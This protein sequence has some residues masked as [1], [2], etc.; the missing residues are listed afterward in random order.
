MSPSPSAPLPASPGASSVLSQQVFQDRHIQHAVRQQLFQPGVFCLKCLQP[1]SIG[2][3][4]ASELRLPFVEGG[5]TD[6]VTPADLRG[7]H[8]TLLFRQDR[9]DL[10]FAE[11]ALPHC[12][13]PCD[14]LSI[15]MRDQSGLRSNSLAILLPVSSSTSPLMSSVTNARPGE[16]NEPGKASIMM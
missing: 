3:V 10:F 14:R 12:L 6:A 16:T 11:F 9:D 2:D 4:H 8:P 1:T 7:R 15:Q 13:S 5:R